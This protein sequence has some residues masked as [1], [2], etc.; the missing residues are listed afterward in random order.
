MKASRLLNVVLAVALVVVS[1]RLAMGNAGAANRASS[2]GNDTADIVYQNIM[3]RASV[4]SYQEKPVEDEKIEKLLHAGMAAPSA[5]NIQ[6]WHF[7]VIKEKATLEKIAELT[8][9]AGM[10]KDAPLAIVV[11]GDMS[12]E[13]EGMVREF[14]S[15]DA[16]AATENILLA[17]HGMGLGAVWT[18][19]YPDPKRCDAIS[20]LL[21]LPS[22]LIPF[23]TIVIGYPKGETQPKDKW[24]P[25]NVSYEHFG[26]SKEDAPVASDV[27]ET[28]KDF[29]EFDVTEDFHGNPFTY[30]KGK[31]LLLAAGDKSNFNEMTIGWGALG[32]I[33]E[34]GMS[35]MTV[36]VAKGRYTFGYMEKARYFTVMEFDDAHKDILEYMGTHSGRDGDK[37]KALGLHTKYT[38]HGTPYF[39]EAKTVFE[40]EM[41]YHAPFDPKG[42]GKM[43]KDFYADFPAGIHSTYMG[44]IVKAMRK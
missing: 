40:C 41:I 1:V 14:W 15:Q 29:E 30:F 43:P 11:C 33:W 39:E 8:P 9:N 23:N 2:S 10:A 35:M 4:R 28:K 3:T 17:A 34:K 16:S 19:T 22:N 38:E 5:V 44:K 12:N 36:Y 13:K 18:G 6:P 20:K 31:G 7:V 21:G 32:N 25:E 37:V 42:F 24:K 27:R 26:G